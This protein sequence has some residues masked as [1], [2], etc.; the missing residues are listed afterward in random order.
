MWNGDL[1]RSIAKTINQMIMGMI[2]V[3]INNNQQASMDED[4]G[5]RV[6]GVWTV[7]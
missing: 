3:P 1:N 4:I 5:G 6:H 7:L 2:N